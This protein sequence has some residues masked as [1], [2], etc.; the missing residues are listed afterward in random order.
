MANENFGAGF[1]IDISNLKNGLAAANKLIRESEAQFKAS[2]AGM[3]NWS[4]SQEGLEKRVDSLNKIVAVQAEKV[5]ALKREKEKIISTMQAEGKSHEEIARAV[6]DVNGKIIKESNALEKHKGALDKA[7]KALDDF[8]AEQDDAADA[9]DGAERELDELT[10]AAKD[11]GDGFSVAKGAISNF[12]ADGLSSLVSK[13]GETI[14]SIANLA[15]E[16][17]EYRTELAK[18]ETAAGESGASADFIKDKWHDVGAVL[19]DEGAVAEGLNNLM[20]AGFTTQEQMDTITQ[21]LEGAAIKWKDTLKFEGLADGLQ[22]TLATGAAVGSFGEMLERSGVNLETFNEGLSKCSTEAEKQNYIMQ[23]LEKLGLSDVSEAYRE[24]N[25]DIIEANKAQSDYTDK[26]AT[27]GKKVEPIQT[28][29]K[30]GFAN[31]LQS[32]IDMTDGIDTEA[33]SGKIEGAFKTF[34]EDIL[35]K[36][37]EGFQW[38][39]DNKDTLIAGIAGIGAAFAAFKVASLINTVVDAMKAFK[40]ANEG[41]TI[42]QT[43]LNAAQNANPMMLIASLV[44]GLVAAL[45]TYIATNE[46]AREKIVEI[47]EK[48]KQAFVDFGA[49]CSEIFGAVKQ[50]FVDL[51]AKASETWES[52]KGVFSAVA[53]WFDENIV[54]PVSGF[55]SDMWSGL[56]QGA[57][58]AWEGVKGAFSSVSTW[59][60]ETFAKAWQKVKDVFSTGGEIFEGIT[61]GITSTFKTVVN[62]I[63]GGINKVISI[64]FEGIN[65]VLSK[66]KSVSIAGAKPFDSLISLIDTPEIPLLAEGGIVNRATHAIIGEAGREAVLP[67][68]KNTE[69]MDMLAEK[70]A[71]KMPSATPVVNQYNNYSHPHSHYELY[72]TKQQTAAAVRLAMKGA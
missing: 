65:G 62:G 34:K 29:V 48:V 13:I 55:F 23:E 7:Q 57:T 35:P 58:E 64:P 26:M 24:Q 2:A 15:D 4:K 20:A 72:K 40:T 50:F 67:L 39:K 47:W 14:G 25:E 18:L 16:T 36:I 10:D 9:A 53:G 45:V 21:H 68:E 11:S 70:L 19:G 1:S 49:K 3:D 41:A 33:I 42:A 38:I 59:F 44:A 63:I 43:L 46:D 6:D 32:V 30:E 71:S 69:W 8:N 61:E 66:I 5:D 31:I 52:I 37:Q 56:T 28:T 27:L 17:R 12:I 22:E 54:Q 51:A 60:E